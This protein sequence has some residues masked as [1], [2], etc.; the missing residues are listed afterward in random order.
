[1]SG[2]TKPMSKI[3][4][5]LQL[6]QQG[7]GKKTIAEILAMS[8][9]TVKSYLF[10]LEG[11]GWNIADL[12]L[13]EDM[14][15]EM[16]FH[17]GNAAYL[18]ARFDDLKN[19]LDYYISELKRKH[20][21]RHLLWQEYK[22]KYSNGYSYAQFCYHIHQHIK[23]KNPSMVL[24]HQPADKLFI[25]FAGKTIDYVDPNTG[26][27]I[28]CQV[29][30]ASLPYSDYGFII[31]V[32]SQSIPDFIYALTRCLE[33]LKGVPQAIVPDNL[34]SA[35][36]KASKYEPDISNTLSDFA[37]HYGTTIVPARVR[38][39][40]DKALVENHVRLFYN[41][42]LAKMRNEQFFSLEQ[43][44]NRFFELNRNLN[45]TRMQQK[46]YSRE[47]KFLAEELPLLKPLPEDPYLIKHYRRYTVM[48]NNHIYL[49]EDKHYYSVPYTYIGHKVK[50]IYTR[51][52]VNIY[53]KCQLIATH[54][55]NYRMGGY[56]T[57]KDHLCS[58][59]QHYLDRSPD[60]YIKKAKDKSN[61]LHTLFEFVFKQDK[62]PE[63][64]YR[65]CDGILHLYAKTPEETFNQAC[66]LAICN[67]IYSYKFISNLIK[68]NMANNQT[69]LIDKPLPTHTN[70]RG[71]EYY[72]QL[73]LNLN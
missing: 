33:D 28:T 35:V 13:L 32:R 51:T 24:T 2:K 60:Y 68:N 47:E 66:Q 72:D 55:R 17:P 37:N 38:K 29:F 30:I 63:Q 62:Y 45:Q 56:S 59:H 15:L 57:L 1:M 11:A 31:A 16:K 61:L 41:H 48:K 21:T 54:I 58:Q 20:V 34:K 8:K 23:V 26:E 67:Q 46:P 9:N 40:Q 19:D 3:K 27:I 5:L 65:S 49:T 42:I 39:P 7:K 43:I 4:Q 10:K 44:N 73:T 64:L 25:D 22:E 12:L 69:E 14:E 50:T 36:V 70:I 53:F 18:E 6:H 52:L 71:K